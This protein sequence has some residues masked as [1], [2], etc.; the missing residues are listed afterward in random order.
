MSEGLASQY[1][2]EPEALWDALSKLL[3]HLE[4]TVDRASFV[5]GCLER[6]VELAG[7]DRGLLILMGS[8]GERDIVNARG[9]GGA[10]TAEERDEISQ[11]IVERAVQERRPILWHAEGSSSSNS[12]VAFGIWKAMAVPLLVDGGTRL[13]GVLYVDLRRRSKLLGDR[14]RE[15][16]RAAGVLIA[17]V[18]RLERRLTDTAGRL[19]Q[20]RARRAEEGGLPSLDELVALP[21]MARVRKELETALHSDLPIL[22][23]GE[24]GSGKTLLAH[25]IAEAADQKPVV[26]AVLGFSD[27]LNTITSQLFG[28]LRGSFSGAHGPR[29]G[30]VEYADGG[31]LIL[32]EVLN[33][34]VQA[35]QLLLDFTQFGTYRPLGYDRREPKRARVRLIAATNG[36][37]QAAMADGRFRSDLYHR[38]AAVELSLPPLRERR[39][40]IPAIV[41]S[42]L[43]RLD[44]PGRWELTEELSNA[45]GS[46]SLRWPG[47]I[48]QLERIV[49][50]GRERARLREPGTTQL[51]LEDVDLEVASP[52]A[53]SPAGGEAAS[54]GD[55]WLALQQAQRSLQDAEVD[56][57]REAL[58]DAGGVVARAARS[59]GVARTTLASRVQTLGLSGV[60]KPGR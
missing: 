49:Q 51:R 57:I 2:P 4:G 11:T 16:I 38:L 9:P 46:R 32:D 17:V 45:L 22:I 27:D 10:L 20:A 58:E 29:E 12:I 14:Q 52:V 50:R 40:E 37:L 35:Q 44:G 19:E 1:E 59:L 60:G 39:E 6:L 18:L 26:R 13:V 42:A 34:P 36:D 48:R 56:L 41:Q 28:H 47:N 30:L 5:D 15:F 55:R 53:A 8:G 3:L 23:T 7:A 24:S 21:S 31:V 43:D 54:I 25:A 33:M